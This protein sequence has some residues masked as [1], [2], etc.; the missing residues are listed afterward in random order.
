MNATDSLTMS[1]TRDITN[2]IVRNTTYRNELRFQK[3]KSLHLAFCRM[4]FVR[5]E[6]MMKNNLKK[7]HTHSSQLTANQKITI[8]FGKESQFRSQ[9][10]D[11]RTVTL[12]CHTETTISGTTFQ[13]I[14]HKT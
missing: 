11:F 6:F 9:A 10:T 5:S 1:P 7:V 3:P 2:I 8:N 12:K 13:T 4:F 14:S